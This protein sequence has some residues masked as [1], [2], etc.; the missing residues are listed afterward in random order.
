MTTAAIASV[1]VV[2]RIGVK[3]LSCGKKTYDSNLPIERFKTCFWSRH[4]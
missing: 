1:A 3:F 4:E 2:E